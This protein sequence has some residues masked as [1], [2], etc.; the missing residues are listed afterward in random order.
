MASDRQAGTA[1]VRRSFLARASAVAGG[2]G[3]ALFAGRVPGTVEAQAAGGFQPAEHAEDAWMDALPG[4]HR[5]IFDTT[6]AAG[7]G[8]ALVFANNFLNASNSG[9]GLTDSDSAVIVVA[10]HSSTAY[11]YN[12]GIW[13]KYGKTLTERTGLHAPG[14]EEAPSVNLFN[15]TIAGLSHRGV[16]IDRLTTRGVHFAVCQMATRFFAGQIA[17]AVGGTVDVVYQELTSSLVANAHMAPAGVVAVN[18]AQ[19]HGYTLTTV[20]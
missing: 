13:A 4:R 17:Q 8:E 3:A 20:V 14:T 15:T 12:D 11:A 9:Y 16:A 1:F 6:T 10:R 18:R 19:E 2:V 7:F 5:A